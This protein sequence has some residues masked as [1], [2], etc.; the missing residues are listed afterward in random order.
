M[1]KGTAGAFAAT[2]FAADSSLPASSDALLI[3]SHRS[4]VSGLPCPSQN[5]PPLQ[6][7]CC[8]SASDI[9]SFI[10]TAKAQGFTN[11]LSCLKS[12]VSSPIFTALSPCAKGDRSYRRSRC[13]TEYLLRL[14]RN[15]RAGIKGGLPLRKFHCKG[16]AG[17]VPAFLAICF[18]KQ[19]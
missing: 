10:S 18:W 16:K 8:M 13:L 11:F 9:V 14:F 12:T 2:I 3:I 1:I 17:G 4:S 15:I 19:V 5:S 6:R 7:S